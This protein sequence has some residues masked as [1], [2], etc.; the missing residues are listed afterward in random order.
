MATVNE[1]RKLMVQY[2]DFCQN[3]RNVFNQLFEKLGIAEND[4]TYCGQEQF[5]L[6]RNVELPNRAVIEQAL[7]KFRV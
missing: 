3:P 2:E 6:T 4:N 5:S 7:A 1:S